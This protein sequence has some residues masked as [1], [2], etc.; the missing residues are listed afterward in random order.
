MPTQ[1]NRTDQ[2]FNSEIQAH[3]QIEVDRLIEEGMDREEA[4]AAARRAF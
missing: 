4:I 1:R 2:D 3:L